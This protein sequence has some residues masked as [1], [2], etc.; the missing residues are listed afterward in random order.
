[1]A[2]VKQYPNGRKYNNLRPLTI[3]ESQ[4]VADYLQYAIRCA[5]FPKRGIRVDQLDDTAMEC[6]Y[7]ALI[8]AVETHD[9]A[10]SALPTYIARLVRLRLIDSWHDQQNDKRKQE[11]QLDRLG[12]TFNPIDPKSLNGPD[13]IEIESFEHAIYDC[14][15]KEKAVLRAIYLDGARGGEL[16]ESAGLSKSRISHF[17]RAGLKG[18]RERLSA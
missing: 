9:S 18:V 17:H 13:F 7:F 1:M 15:H 2:Y 16:A 6:V 4:T 8:E 5:Q 12:G 11:N 14:H 10:K 3:E